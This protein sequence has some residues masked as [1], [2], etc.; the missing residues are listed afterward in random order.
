[1]AAKKPSTTTA[2]AK[3]KNLPLDIAALMKQEAEQLSDKIASPS[4][5][6]MSVEKNGKVKMP[7]GSEGDSVEGIILGFVSANLYYDRPYSRDVIYPPACFAIGDRPSDLVPDATS[8]VR[9]ND[10]CSSC[11]MNQFGSATNGK[12]KAC[13]NRRLAAF[14]PLDSEEVCILSVP[15]SGIKVFDAYVSGLTVKHKRPPFGVLTSI[16]S[17]ISA[18]DYAVPEFSFERL[19][20]DDEITVAYELREAAT[21]RLKVA[22]DVSS[23]EPPARGRNQP[24]PRKTR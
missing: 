14:L 15:P 20:E 23:Y 13:G 9:Q 2:A 8:P 19:L 10:S 16:S 21:A 5:D 22:P 11:P 24:T 4:G 7:D 3:P 17:N 18:G 12:G 1:M 6:K